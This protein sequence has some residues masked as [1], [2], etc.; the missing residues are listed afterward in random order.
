MEEKIGQCA[1]TLRFY[2][3]SPPSLPCLPALVRKNILRPPPIPIPTNNPWRGE[4]WM[5]ETQFG[6][7]SR[8]AELVIVYRDRRCFIN[9]QEVAAGV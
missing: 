6:L 9:K 5:G 4:D 8:R 2:S 1:L 3:S 7:C